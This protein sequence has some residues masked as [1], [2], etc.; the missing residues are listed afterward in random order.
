[1]ELKI[2]M[3][4]P[5]RWF[6]SNASAVQSAVGKV[7]SSGQFILGPQVKDFETAFA[8]FCHTRHA[9]AVASG[10]DA[11][12]LILRALDVAGGEVIT[13]AHTAIA[14]LAAIEQAGAKPVLADIN[15]LNRCLHPNSVAALLSP[16]TRAIVAVHMFGHPADM[17]ALSEIAARQ[18]IPLVEDCAQAHGAQFRDSPVGGLGVAGAFSFYPTKNLAAMGDAGMIVC[19]DEQLASRIF[20]LRQYG[21]DA[22]RISQVPG[23]N[24]RMDDIQAAILQ[25]RLASF[26]TDFQ[27]RRL[28]AGKYKDAL[29]H[30]DCVTAPVEL[31]GSIHAYH[32]FAIESGKRDQVASALARRGISTALHYPVMAHRHPAYSKLR[33]EGELP[34]VNKLYDRMLS[35][36]LY[37]ELTDVEVERVCDALAAIDNEASN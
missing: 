14:T 8:R 24:S 19:S 10:T 23:C 15:P 4:A 37:P 32:V 7:L 30:S 36:P 26:A 9:V 28:I 16:E 18:D 34:Q 3:A 33:I 27:R 11:I 22:E 2:P 5:G 12:T 6:N 29:K 25:L 17:E 13:S 35:I 20:Q 1:M 21:W 31:E